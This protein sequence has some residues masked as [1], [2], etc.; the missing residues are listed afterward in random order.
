MLVA[1]G[2]VV[3][4]V[5]LVTFGAIG[6]VWW[7]GRVEPEPNELAELTDDELRALLAREKCSH[8]GGV[9]ERACPRV[10]KMV[11]HE[12]T[13]RL[14]HVEFADSFDDTAVVWPEPVLEE[15]HR[16]GISADSSEEGAE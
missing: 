14:L 5:A 8:C 1:F 7:Y 12:N 3:A 4:T 9:H 11:F 15:L 2:A 10:R 16:R 6:A 13:G